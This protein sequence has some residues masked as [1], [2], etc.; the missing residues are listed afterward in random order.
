MASLPGQTIDWQKQIIALLQ[1]HKNV[2]VEEL[3]QMNTFET[4]L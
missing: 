4:T 1:T 2:F 3:G